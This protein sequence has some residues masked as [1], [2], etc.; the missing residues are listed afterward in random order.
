MLNF[1]DQAFWRNLESYIYGYEYL[2]PVISVVS[3]TWLNEM[4]GLRKM[5]STNNTQK[6]N[7]FNYKEMSTPLKG[8]KQKQK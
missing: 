4:K 7:K 1:I 5:S 3:M 2:E 8:N 6:L